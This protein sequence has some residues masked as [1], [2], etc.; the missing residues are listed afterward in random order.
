MTNVYFRAHASFRLDQS[1]SDSAL[2][3]LIKLGLG[4]RVPDAVTILGHCR[5]SA[6]QSIRESKKEQTQRL[7]QERAQQ[8]PI[9]LYALSAELAGV[10]IRKYT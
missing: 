10:V 9:L 4:S 6:E 1:L 8:F 5:S 7:T 3:L 2:D